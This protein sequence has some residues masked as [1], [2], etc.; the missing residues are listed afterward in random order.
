MLLFE[1]KEKSRKPRYRQL[2]EQIRRRIETGHLLPDEKLPSTRRL[3]DKLGLHRSTVALAY[4]E[5]WALGY[6]DLHPG[7]VPRVRRRMPM[8]AAADPDGKS[9]IRWQTTAS[10]AADAI[11][12]TFRDRYPSVAG[13]P[14]S[15]PIDFGSLD[16]DQRLFPLENFRSSLNRALQKRGPALLGYGDRAGLPSLRKTIALR[17]RNHGIRVTSDEILL[18]NGSQQGIDLVLRMIAAP[19][20]SVAIESPTYA[21]LLPLIR[22]YGLRAVEIPIRRDGMDLAML[23][24]EISRGKPSLVYTMPNFQNPTGLSSSQVHREQLLSLC[25]TNRIPILE[26]G[27]EE[28]MKYFGKVVMPIKSMDKHHLV[29]YCGTFSKVLFPGVRIGWIAAERECIERLVAIRSF[30]ELSPPSILQAAID[31]FCRNGFYDRHITRMHRVFR[32]R[33][34]AAL[35]SLHLHIRPEWAEWTEPNGGYLI[36]LKLKPVPGRSPDWKTLLAAHGVR[37]SMGDSFFFSRA[38]DTHMR[39]SISTLNEEEI[40]EGARRLSGA[41]R[42]AHSG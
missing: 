30:S 1:I 17:L 38:R 14:A 27:F 35:H 3:A 5:L 26:D 15:A 11:W 29:I 39:L 25:E 31:E 22:F 6:V 7:S 8:T 20:R 42:R 13:K 18:T 16:M 28:E 24:G 40:D 4:Q 32:K 34:Q 12:R 9:L 21:Q 33:M 41:L 19:A 23:A 36:W 2:I 37:A 10:P